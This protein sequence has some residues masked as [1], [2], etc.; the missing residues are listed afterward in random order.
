[1]ILKR[2]LKLKMRSASPQWRDQN[3]REIV[4]NHEDSI[5]NIYETLVSRLVDN[6]EDLGELSVDKNGIE[7]D[8]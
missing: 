1:M 6:Q 4:D 8:N 7:R 2:L 5:N 3:R